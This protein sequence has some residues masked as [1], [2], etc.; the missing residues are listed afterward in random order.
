MVYLITKNITTKQ[1]SKNS[2]TSISNLTKLL[3]KFKKK[4]TTN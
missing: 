1:P 2:T 4:T 3:R